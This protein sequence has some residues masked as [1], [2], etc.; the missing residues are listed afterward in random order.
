MTNTGTIYVKYNS[1]LG[2][3]DVKSIIAFNEF[4]ETLGLKN[5]SRADITQTLAF[6][7]EQKPLYAAVNFEKNAFIG[8]TSCYN[9]YTVTQE[10]FQ[11]QYRGKH[12]A[13]KF[14]F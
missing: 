3:P 2:Y 6:L 5:K 7:M 13:K 11:H 4:L 14:G 1:I 8:S 12:A 9:G 10:E